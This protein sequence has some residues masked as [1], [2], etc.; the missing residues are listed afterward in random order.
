MTRPLTLACALGLALTPATAFAGQSTAGWGTAS[1]ATPTMSSSASSAWATSG[2][3]GGQTQAEQSNTI[4]SSDTQIANSVA[5][6]RAA[7]TTNSSITACGYCVFIN[8]SGNANSINGNSFTGTNSG[9]ITNTG[10]ISH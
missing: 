2:G 8:V 6:G 1:T 4:H 10:T 3:T 9:S 7:S 5:E